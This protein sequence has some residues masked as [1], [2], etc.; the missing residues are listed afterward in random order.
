MNAKNFAD[1]P[2]GAPLIFHPS[3]QTFQPRAANQWPVY[4]AQMDYRFDIADA[5]ASQEAAL[6]GRLIFTKLILPPG[7]SEECSKYLVSKGIT[8]D[9]VFPV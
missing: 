2:L 5:W 1:E 9:V 3:L 4:I 7:S 6:D 8:R